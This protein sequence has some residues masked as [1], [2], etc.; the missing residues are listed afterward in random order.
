LIRCEEE[1]ATSLKPM[2]GYFASMASA[3]LVSMGTK[4]EAPET[5]ALIAQDGIEIFVDLEGLIDKEAEIKRLE[6]EEKKLTGNIGGKEKKL[7]NEKFV[8][9]APPEI[10]QRER[11]SLEQL[12]EQ[13]VKVQAALEKFKKA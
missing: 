13:L 3:E 10:V 4:V 5:N 11:D 8:S 2:V 6:K 1:Y 12:K 9:S 7:S